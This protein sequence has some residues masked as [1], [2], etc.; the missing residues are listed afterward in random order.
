MVRRGESMILSYAD[1]EHIAGAV[2]E[3][4]YGGTSADNERPFCFP[5]ERFASTYLGLSVAYARLSNDGSVLGVTAYQDI[6]YVVRAG[7]VKKI[8]SLARNQVL[9]DKSLAGFSESISAKRRRRFTL[10]HECAHQIL[11]QLEDQEG[12]AACRKPYALCMAR[13]PRLLRTS[14]DWREW[15]ANALGSALIMPAD[16]LE[17]AIRELHWELPLVFHDGYPTIRS[18]L[19]I[20]HLCSRFSVSRA[21]LTIRLRLLGFITQDKPEVCA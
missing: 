10:A 4:F 18:K 19:L 13:R 3:D 1:I 12:A 8:I 11:F 15:Q 6:E 5:I 7:D 17:Q 14:E 16:R 20:E 9:L 2:S 21:A